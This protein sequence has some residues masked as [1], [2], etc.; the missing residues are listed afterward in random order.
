MIIGKHKKLMIKVLAENARLA[1]ENKELRELLVEHTHSQEFHIRES[2]LKLQNFM[3][4]MRTE[5]R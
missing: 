4:E 1:K 5:Q 2:T 3:E